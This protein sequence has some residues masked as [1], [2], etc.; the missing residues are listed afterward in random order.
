MKDGWYWACPRCKKINDGEKWWETTRE[1][2]RRNYSVDDE[3]QLSMEDD[4]FVEGE[5]IQVEHYC[6]D[7]GSFVTHNYKLENFLI[8]VENNKIVKCG[9][10]YLENDD[11]LEKIARANAL[12][13][14]MEK[15]EEMEI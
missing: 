12:E 7:G 13:I 2:I 6:G 3:G 15:D 14:D 4:E 5:V 9:D 8:K 1:T 10:Y 11:E